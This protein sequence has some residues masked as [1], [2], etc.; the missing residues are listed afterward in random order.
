M[1]KTTG[2]TRPRSKS[3]RWTKTKK[4]AFLDHL[5]A[6]CNIT[7]AA[8]VIG[9]PLG[10]VY[11]KRRGDPAFRAQWEDALACGYQMLETRLV[12]LALAGGTNA[13]DLPGDPGEP[14]VCADYAMRLLAMRQ[15]VSAGRRD[16]AHRPRTPA[17]KDE[18]T[19][20]ILKKL[21][22]IERKATA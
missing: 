17:G 7:A 14:P 3:I 12:G 6:T 10:S 22:A 9:A 21:A 16:H 4:D 5:A 1:D 15:S 20:A 13:D 2:A 18:T 11:H 19:A 8:A